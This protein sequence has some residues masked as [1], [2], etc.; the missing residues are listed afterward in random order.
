MMKN[1]NQK[2]INWKQLLTENSALWAL[3]FLCIVATVLLGN[4]FLNVQNI[5]NILMGNAIIGIIALGMTLVIIVGGIDLSVGSVSVG[6]GLVALTVMNATGNILLGI[7][8]AIAAGVL[9][10]AISGTL[11][12]AFRLPAFIAT[13]G[14]MRVYRSVAQHYFS[15]GAAILD[16]DINEGFLSIAN[17]QIG[18]LVPL[19]IIYWLGLCMMIDLLTKKTAFGR[20]IYAVGSN[21][22]ATNLSGINTAKIKILVYMVSG[23]LVA[24]AAIVEA[25]RMGSM[26]ST[27]SGGSYELEAIAA[28]VIGGAAM[29][30]GKGRIMGTLFGTLTLGVIN[31]MMNQ[32]GFPSFLVGAIQGGIIIVA[33]LIQR[34]VAKQEKQ[35]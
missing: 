4:S 9:M 29:S 2:P 30:G 23:F 12:A 8:A 21:E 13:L 28:V 18:G 11:I 35:Y 22:R 15:G 17:T 19:P 32:L 6:S 27:A 31:N 24:I 5:T 34:L 10:G 20:H 26:N 14:L 3:I 16:R 33:V 7:L 1:S 25:S